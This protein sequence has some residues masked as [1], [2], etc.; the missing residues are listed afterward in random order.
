MKFSLWSS[1]SELPRCTLA[2]FQSIKRRL[3][4][5]PLVESKSNGVWSYL[6]WTLFDILPP[7]VVISNLWWSRSGRCKWCTEDICKL[8]AI[9]VARSATMQLPVATATFSTVGVPNC[10]D[11]IAGGQNVGKISYIYIPHTY[12]VIL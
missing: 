9:F 2:L 5:Q 6:I 8:Y 11:L 12:K 1:W 3:P 4:Q 10:S 7:R